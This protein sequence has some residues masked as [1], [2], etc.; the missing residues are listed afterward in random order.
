MKVHTKTKGRYRKWA[1][2]Y[3]LFCVRYE[4]LNRVS[5]VMLINAVDGNLED[6][7]V[8]WEVQTDIKII[9]HHCDSYC[10]SDFV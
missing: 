6:I 5:L 2:D 3:M 9:L 10:D 4:A 1:T 7:T 8:E